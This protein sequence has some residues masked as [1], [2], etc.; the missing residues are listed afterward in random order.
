M[1]VVGDQQGALVGM[2]CLSR[3]EAKATYGTGGFVLFNTGE[4]VV[5]SCHGLISTVSKTRQ[6]DFDDSI[7]HEER[8]RLAIQPQI[9]RR[10]TLWKDPYLLRDQLSNGFETRCI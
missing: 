1:G 6:P 8:D 3:G 4:E 7:A 10:Y 9:I 2:K 5:K